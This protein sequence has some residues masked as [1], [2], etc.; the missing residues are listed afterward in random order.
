MGDRYE[1]LSNKFRKPLEIIKTEFNTLDILNET[2]Y[3]NSQTILEF[4]CK[5][6]DIIFKK[7]VGQLK[8]SGCPC[9]KAVASDKRLKTT[10]IFSADSETRKFAWIE[11]CKENYPD[12]FCYD[13]VI[14]KNKHTKVIV[15]CMKC[16]SDFEII[17]HQLSVLR[18]RN[19]IGCPS[20]NC[21][22]RGLIRSLSK[23]EITNRIQDK[24]RVIDWNNYTN[25]NAK[26]VVKCNSCEKE[27]SARINNLIKSMGCKA[28]YN[29]RRGNTLRFSRETMIQKFNQFWNNA[30]DYS[31]VE[32]I[33][34]TTNV[35]VTCKE[36]GDFEI[37]PHAHER[38]QG[39]P[40]CI[41]TSEKRLL[42]LLKPHF[43]DIV[44]QYK[45]DQCKRINYLPFDFYI[46]SYNTI[47]ELD[48]DQHFKCVKIWK[49]DAERQL[50]R[51]IYKMKM[52]EKQ[53]I[54]VIRVY[55]P[56]VYRKSDEWI[57]KTLLPNIIENTNGN[58]FISINQEVYKKHKEQVNSTY[59]KVV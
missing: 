54:R 40:K 39:C 20:C 27:T 1:I 11:K 13:K 6:C 32:Y 18:S 23:N 5:Q 4:K 38:G 51:D 56:D 21:K 37:I 35:T 45:M 31:K 47:I 30:Y 53:G 43:P 16:N 17:P 33:N 2:Q 26:I 52:A 42:E 14:Y 3:K 44:Y 48:G 49:S 36:H 57:M 10:Q 41:P 9:C 58:I 19:I 46:P 24:W 7:R 59:Q 22:E 8:K 15:G 12:L 55:Q 29:K 50:E 28:C 34:M 25:V